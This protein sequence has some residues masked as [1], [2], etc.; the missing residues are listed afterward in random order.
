ML[1]VSARY[2][3][4]LDAMTAYQSAPSPEDPLHSQDH[5]KWDRLSEL[6]DAVDAYKREKAEIGHLDAEGRPAE[7]IKGKA[8]ARIEDVERIGEFADEGP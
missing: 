2:Q 8:L 3:R 4:V 5:P 6:K 7:N 1:G